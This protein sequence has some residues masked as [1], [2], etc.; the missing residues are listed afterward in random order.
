MLIS[1]GLWGLLPCT[2]TE[3][4]NA[5][6]GVISVTDKKLSA[7]HG[8]RQGAEP[9]SERER[10]AYITG[11]RTAN[12]W[13]GPGLQHR[14]IDGSVSRCHVSVSRCLRTERR[15]ESPWTWLVLFPVKMHLLS[16][17][18]CWSRA[19]NWER[20]H[21]RLIYWSTSSIKQIMRECNVSQHEVNCICSMTPLQLEEPKNMKKT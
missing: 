8:V 4:W 13:P 6:A 14:S 3:R 5:P 12:S 10:H 17:S 1:S 20:K 2:G 19:K 16:L 21:S 18:M 9:H 11:S 7:Q 15:T